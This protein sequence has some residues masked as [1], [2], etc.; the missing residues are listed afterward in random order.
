MSKDQ[1]VMALRAMGAKPPDERFMSEVFDKIIL[2]R[3]DKC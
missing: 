3:Y 1:P 2:K